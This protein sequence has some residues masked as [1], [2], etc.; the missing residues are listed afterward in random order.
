[1]FQ[2]RQSRLFDATVFSFHPIS[3]GKIGRLLSWKSITNSICL[4]FLQTSEIGNIF[5]LSCRTICTMN[6]AR[7][8]WTTL[9]RILTDDALCHIGKALSRIVVH[10]C[11]LIPCAITY[12]N[13]CFLIIKYNKNLLT[14]TIGTKLYAFVII[15]MSQFVSGCSALSCIVE[16]LRKVD[17]EM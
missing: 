2:A 8:D 6:T 16:C 4:F 5:A 1:M 10:P 14:S 9:L 17:T 3:I 7:L 12:Y 15:A 13:L 11:A